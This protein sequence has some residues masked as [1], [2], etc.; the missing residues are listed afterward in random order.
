[1]PTIVVVGDANEGGEPAKNIVGTLYFP[2]QNGA[3][4][5]S[6]DCTAEH[7]LADLD[8]D[9]L[10]DVNLARIP[11]D[12]RWEVARSVQTY[13]NF[14]SADSSAGALFLSGDLDEGD[15]LAAPLH[16]TL[17]DVRSMYEAAGIATVLRRDS[18]YDWYDNLT[19]QM[20]VASDLNAGVLEVFAMGA[21]SNRSRTP[22]MFIQKVVHPE[23]DMGWLTPGP[24]PFVFWGPGCGMADVDRDNPL[25]D[26]TLAEEFL[27]GDPDRSAAVAWVSHGRGNWSTCH[28]LFARELVLWRFSGCVSDVLD[29]FTRAKNSCITKYPDTADY[30][31][32]LFFLGWPARL[33]RMALGSVPVT[34]SAFGGAVLRCF[35]NPFNPT[36]TVEYELAREGRARL[37]VYDVRGRLVVR[38]V[39][40]AQARGLHRA[41]WAG[42]DARGLRVSSGVYFVRLETPDGVV[43]RKIVVAK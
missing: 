32:G 12:R 8:F 37:D 5:F 39:D 6:D 7:D 36:T 27:F 1:M 11:A 38:L 14:L 30:V 16:E 20:D 26:P 42:L 17:V 10:A 33:P 41:F 21:I 9:G 22:G 3:C 31:R 35:P 43:A 28:V 24:H 29:C 40:Q 34:G 19:R 2:D 23:W 4:Y 13:I 25:Y 15:V 18:E